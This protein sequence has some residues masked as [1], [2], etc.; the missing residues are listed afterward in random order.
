MISRRALLLVPPAIRGRRHPGAVPFGVSFPAKLD[1][2]QSFVR[3]A[4]VDR[5]AVN[6]SSVGRSVGRSAGFCFCRQIKCRQRLRLIRRNSLQSG[7]STMS[8]AWAFFLVGYV[9]GT[10]SAVA[11]S[12]FGDTDVS[13]DEDSPEA[14][15]NKTY[16]ERQTQLHMDIFKNYDKYVRPIRNTSAPMQVSIHAYL[17]HVIVD[18]KQQT[19]ELNGH[20]YMSWS[21]E[22]LTWD[23]TAYNGV[24]TTIVRQWE[25]WQPELRIANSAAGVNSYYEISKWSHVVLQAEKKSSTRVDLWPTFSIKLGCAFDFTDYPYDVQKCPLV[26]YATKRMVE[27]ELTTYYG[28][29]PTIVLGWGDQAAKRHISDWELTNISTEVSYFSM[30]K[31]TKDKPTTQ[32]D[33]EN[34][35]TMMYTWLTLRRHAPYFGVCVAL[36]GVISAFLN[37]GSFWTRKAD[38]G[39]YVLI[40]NLFVEGIFTRDLIMQLPPSIGNPPRIVRYSAFNMAL[41]LLAVLVQLWIKSLSRRD[42]PMSACFVPFVNLSTRIPWNLLPKAS[43]QANAKAPSATNGP[44]EANVENPEEQVEQPTG[45]DKLSPSYTEEWTRLAAVLRLL[46]A[47][48]YFLVYFILVL[49]LLT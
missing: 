43:Q 25:I 29:Q 6:G 5:A 12:S 3:L 16:S 4:R 9:L 21:D 27:V 7:L 31:Y 13:A 35:W 30:G 49:A 19:I 14:F 42:G 15:V 34:S 17:M 38:Y 28:V 10:S 48:S 20:F 40:A 33:L 2:M 39:I 45:T 44:T 22:Y 1:T 32:R 18:A 36:P 11:T 47:I 23:P 37:C 46:F 41:T 26:L 8:P 24:R